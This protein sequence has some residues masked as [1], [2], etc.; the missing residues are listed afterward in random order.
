VY[1]KYR[2]QVSSRGGKRWEAK[3]RRERDK[4]VEGCIR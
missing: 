3:G 2:V 4:E 1:I